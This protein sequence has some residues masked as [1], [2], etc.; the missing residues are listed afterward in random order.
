[1]RQRNQDAR[2]APVIPILG[3]RTEAQILDNLGCL[4]TALT[5]E[6]LARLT[7]A[8]QFTMGFPRNFLE[9]DHVRGLIF[10]ETFAHLDNHR[11]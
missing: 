7:A 3:A 8:S 4:D 6:Q 1:M 2:H 5:Q 9:S 11:A 10:G